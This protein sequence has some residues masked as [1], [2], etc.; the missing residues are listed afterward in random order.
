MQVF[1]LCFTGWSFVCLSVSRSLRISKDW[2]MNLLKLIL[3][4]LSS[5]SDLFVTSSF[6]V[7]NFKSMMFSIACCVLCDKL[8]RTLKDYFKIIINLWLIIIYANFLPSFSFQMAQVAM[9]PTQKMMLWIRRLPMAAFDAGK[10]EAPPCTVM[11]QVC[12]CHPN[13]YIV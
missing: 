6:W 7:F 3:C 10:I 4:A 1:L 2:D 13:S 11:A 5:S 12:R 9:D 8:C